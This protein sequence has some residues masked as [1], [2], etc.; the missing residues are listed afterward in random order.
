M[1]DLLER[2]GGTP[3]VAT[4]LDSPRRSRADSDAGLIRRFVRSR[5]EQAFE[6]L[7][8]RY[9]PL[10]RGVCARALTAN[11]DREDVYQATFLTLFLRAGTIRR[12]NSVACWLYG[13]AFRIA[14]RLRRK[15]KLERTELAFDP[16]A[17]LQEVWVQIDRKHLSEVL[18][19]EM[20]ALPTRD[21]LP[22]AMHYLMGLS[23]QEIG[24]SLG[25]SAAAVDG[26]LKRARQRLRTRLLS[27]GVGVA[28]ALA[29]F[30]TCLQEARAAT[31]SVEAGA[32]AETLFQL[33]DGGADASSISS[34]AQGLF[35]EE[36]SMMAVGWGKGV[37]VAGGAALACC[38]LLGIFWGASVGP[39][40]AQA[41][42]GGG[43]GGMGGGGMGGG[44]YPGTYAEPRGPVV[45]VRLAGEQPAAQPGEAKFFS[46]LSEPPKTKAQLSN[47]AEVDL[48]ETPL[49]E[50]LEGLGKQAGLEIQIDQTDLE[51]HG[52]TPDVP[53]NLQ[54]D[55]M[56]LA[57]A[58]DALLSPMTLTYVAKDRYILVTSK[59]RA[60]QMMET[61]MYAMADHPLL[62]TADG[63]AL[64]N[65][66]TGH[67]EPD[68]WMVVGGYG[69]VSLLPGVLIVTNDQKTLDQ[70]ED[71]L[72]QYGRLLSKYQPVYP[73]G[74]D[75]AAMMG[76]GAGME[77]T[78]NSYSAGP[79]YGGEG[80][81]YGEGSQ[82]MR[83]VF[84]AARSPE[85]ARGGGGFFYGG[86]GGGGGDAE[87]EES[88]E[89]RAEEDS[90]PEG[91]EG[92]AIDSASGMPAPAS[93]SG[94]DPSGPIYSGI[95]HP[96]AGP[97]K[98]AAEARAT[99]PA[100]VYAPSAGVPGVPGSSGPAA[101][102]PGFRDR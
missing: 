36:A 54:S 51:D 10:V 1:S 77:G 90:A 71:F 84:G 23:H 42:Y 57:D 17:D 50:A 65:A 85:A 8:R 4:E 60:S 72:A 76:M 58:L 78:Y 26:R 62:R 89:E 96:A 73:A 43:M 47:P 15:R 79:A 97:P 44:Y 41:Q 59:D 64:V 6:E 69:S 98:D 100:A 30:A 68:S 5:D 63:S 33:F 20:Q 83:G 55:S 95:R 92:A 74:N 35:A 37:L 101:V 88:S 24:R 38:G 32:G 87:Q 93:A 28:S 3:S 48:V 31:A 2:D 99:G 13:V 34:D 61:R 52:I 102:P 91:N 80:S 53:V 7:E 18:D 56:T 67:I 70:V 19:A 49:G 16:P 29:Y 14:T 9:G 66:I 46:P 39:G 25:I 82:P 21:R 12:R 45:T 86:E 81:P 22:L 75:D 94:Y 27:R 40:V 11:E